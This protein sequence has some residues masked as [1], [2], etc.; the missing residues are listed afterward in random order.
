MVDRQWY[1]KELTL[2]A[3]PWKLEADMVFYKPW[4]TYAMVEQD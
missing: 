4:K 3:K 1:K 2:I